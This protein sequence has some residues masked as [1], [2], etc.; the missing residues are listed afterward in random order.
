M[1]RPFALI[2]AVV[3]A[4]VVFGGLVYAV[5]V[6]A[7]VAEPA[8]TTVQ[9]LTTRRLWATASAVLALVA[10]GWLWSAPRVASAPCSSA[11]PTCLSHRAC[12]ASGWTPRGTALP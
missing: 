11:I 1:K 10:V 2:L 6:A 9:N 8:A 4:V 7:H 5:L 12:R 3:A